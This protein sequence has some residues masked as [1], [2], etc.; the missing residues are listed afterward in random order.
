MDSFELSRV[1]RG[2]EERLSGFAL[3][4]DREHLIDDSLGA[5]DPDECR[6]DGF[7]K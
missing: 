2:D 7:L 5:V 3:V 4:V 6:A 1:R